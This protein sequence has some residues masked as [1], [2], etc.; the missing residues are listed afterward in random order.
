MTDAMPVTDIYGA[1]L[2]GELEPR[3]SRRLTLSALHEGRFGRMFR[4]LSPMPPY[5]QD[6]LEQ[7]AQQMVD[8]DAPTSGWGG[9]VE[10]RDNPE[11]PAGYT[12]FG[13]FL[14]HD[15]TFDPVSS[16][17]RNNDP[18]ALHNF[19][20]PRL[21]LDSIYGSGPVDEPFQYVRQTRG[22]QLLAEPNRNGV[23]DLPRNSQDVA[24]IGDPRNDENTIVGQ[25]HLA[26]IKLHNKLGAEVLADASVPDERKFE[27]AQQRVRW[28][29]QWAVVHD[30]I[31]RVIGPDT[32]ET[33]TSVD[34]NGNVNEVHTN[35]YRPKNEAYMPVE[36]SGA[37][38][39]YGHSQVRGVYN[40]NSSVT[41]R[42]I[43][44]PGPL[45]DELADLRGFRRLPAGWSIDWSLFFP[46]GGSTPQ[47]GRLIDSRLVPAL[48][49]LPEGGSLA[50]RNLL[51]GQI[52]GLPS[53]QD[54][55][56][57]LR[58]EPLSTAELE[59]APDPTPL[60]FYI[61][62]ETEKRAAGKHLGPV[63]GRIVGE[64]I[65]GLVELDKQ[66][67][68]N[69]EPTW[70]PSIPDADGD[71]KIGVPDLVSFASS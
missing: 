56:K 2:H 55:A 40:L 4:R 37:A 65:L 32:F 7:L 69:I 45:P 17:Q 15:I 52:L 19:R 27:V 38:Y 41:D 25:L 23:E 14:D 48:S 18:D 3:G 10:P 62:K 54:V 1:P 22:L 5:P 51:K 66:S 50:L 34:A 16:S 67:W 26:F 46:I 11:I 58:I 49:V 71:G 13:Q 59:G 43:F 28:H 42:P 12:Y 68:L 53:G 33:L 70:T 39:R 29:Y 6:V 24:L 8:E 35:F 9:T 30:F 31:P 61:L 44:I 64:V 63:G 47:P 36:F 21:D 60:W 20:S 57:L